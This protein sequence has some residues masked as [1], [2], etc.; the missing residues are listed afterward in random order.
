MKTTPFHHSN[1]LSSSVAFKPQEDRRAARKTF[2]AL[3]PRLFRPAQNALF[4]GARYMRLVDAPAIFNTSAPRPTVGCGI[5]F[6][7]RICRSLYDSTE[8][9][10]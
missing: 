10:R 1:N 3:S 5:V 2:I 4:K 6:A 8:R 7:S 9:V